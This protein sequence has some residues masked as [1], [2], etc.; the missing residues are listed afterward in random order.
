MSYVLILAAG[1][2]GY[3]LLAEGIA[4]A[5]LLYITRKD[6]RDDVP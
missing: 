4:L 1:F 5:L 2:V 3:V 6:H